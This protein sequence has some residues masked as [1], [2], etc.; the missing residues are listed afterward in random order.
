MRVSPPA[1][2]PPPEQSSAFAPSRVMRRR[3]PGLPPAGAAELGRQGARRAV[4]IAGT[5]PATA[6]RHPTSGD[7]AQQ[8]QEH[9]RGAAPNRPRPAAV[10]RAADPR[11]TPCACHRG[12]RSRPVT[13]PVKSLMSV[14]A[15]IPASLRRSRTDLG[16]GSSWRGS[17]RCSERHDDRRLD[18]RL[19][20]GT[21]DILA[22]ASPAGR[23][24]SM[25]PRASRAAR[26][27]AVT[28]VSPVMFIRS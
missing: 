9:A 26:C 21:G 27:A 13:L 24:C 16:S 20:Y 4:V 19:S 22:V 17:V 8:R 28:P 12:L 10:R 5:P 11:P 18:A 6:H 23:S 25:A 7:V 2:A 15:T 3:R 14:A 1:A